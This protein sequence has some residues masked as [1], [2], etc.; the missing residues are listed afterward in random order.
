MRHV[1]SSRRV[2]AEGLLVSGRAWLHSRR[3]GRSLGGEAT[4]PSWAFMETSAFW[5]IWGVPQ[6]INSE[7]Y[8]LIVTLYIYIY[9]YIWGFP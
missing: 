5:Q 1:D 6:M 3:R 8:W 7:K 2:G 4:C 9:I